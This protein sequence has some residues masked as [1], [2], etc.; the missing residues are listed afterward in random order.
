MRVILGRTLSFVFLAVLAASALFSASPSL[1]QVNSN[2]D[3]TATAVQATYDAS[4]Q[5]TIDALLVQPTLSIEE[6][7]A[8]TLQALT[9]TAEP[10]V[11]S[12]PRILTATAESSIILNYLVESWGP[13][14]GEVI[15][16]DG[17]SE[18]GIE[19]ITIEF[20]RIGN[21]IVSGEMGFVG[22]M[23]QPGLSGV[24]GEYNEVAVRGQYFTDITE[25]DDIEFW[26]YIDDFDDE[27]VVI[28]LELYRIRQIEANPKLSNVS[29][30]VITRQGIM[31]GATYDPDRNNDL[32]FTFRLAPNEED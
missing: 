1:S 15:S 12:D 2:G 32:I 19:D 4:V 30:A 10:I 22:V 11:T 14:V 25:L 9:P 16:N 6:A 8:A 13:G 7:V 29:L 27:D 3:A 18:F 31:V 24:G 17:Y 23:P 20:S 28:W 21:G 5:A 26:N